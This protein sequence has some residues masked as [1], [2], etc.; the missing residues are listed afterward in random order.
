L[1]RAAFPPPQDQ[2]HDSERGHSATRAR[3]HITHSHSHTRTHTPR[4]G[5]EVSVQSAAKGSR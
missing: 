5:P 4:G 2:T 1:D 3:T